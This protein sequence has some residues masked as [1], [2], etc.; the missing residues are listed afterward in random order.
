M[1]KAYTIAPCSSEQKD[2]VLALAR[3]GFS[4]S[5]CDEGIVDLLQNVL[6]IEA[7]GHLLV[8]T[9]GDRVV[10]F[11]GYDFLRDDPVLKDKHIL[12]DLDWGRHKEDERILLEYR[13]EEYR[14]YG[15]KTYGNGG[16]FVEYFENQFTV[17]ETIQPQ[18]ADMCLT[19]L[20]VDPAFQRRG[21]GQALTEARINIAK[22]ENASAGYVII[23]DREPIRRMYEKLDFQSI[24]RYSPGYSDGSPMRLLGLRL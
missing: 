22:Q 23:W 12:V 17:D 10:G 20:V 15:E 24:I 18:D 2:A 7:R 3:D 11:A 6:A 9:L 1:I 4:P 21:I 13:A 14:Q 16:V 8:A 5:F 19:H